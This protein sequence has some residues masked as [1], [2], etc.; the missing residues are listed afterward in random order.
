[1][2]PEEIGNPHDLQMWLAVN[3]KTM[4]DSS[5]ANMIFGIPQIISYVSQFMTLLPGDIIS[6]GTPSGVGF[7]RNPQRFLQAGVDPEKAEKSR[8]HRESPEESPL[9]GRCVG[10]TA[11]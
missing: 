3:G 6:T 9:A 11:Q 2:T 8:H 5:T 10:G 7:G 1:M 4:Q